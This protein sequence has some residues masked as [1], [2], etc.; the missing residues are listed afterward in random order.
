MAACA[1]MTNKKLGAK[2]ATL[3]SHEKD[4]HLNRGR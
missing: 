2:G 3:P 1:A 4:S